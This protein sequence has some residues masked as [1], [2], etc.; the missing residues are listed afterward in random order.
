MYD[1]QC[2]GYAAAYLS[3]QC[4]LDTLYD[5]QCPGY[6]T[7]Y[8]NQQ[9]GI[10]ALYDSQCPG[11]AEAFFTQQ[12]TISGLY[13]TTCPNYDT[14]YFENQCTLDSLYNPGCSGYAEAKAIEDATPNIED[15]SADTVEEI[16]ENVTEI[17]SVES[18][19][20]VAITGDTIVDSVINEESTVAVA[21][22][23]EETTTD[24]FNVV[25]EEV[26]IPEE[27]AIDCLL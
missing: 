9:C 21:E 3:Q 12:C 25:V 11:Y 1:S 7:A 24:T 22:L 16:A 23:I 14:A 26:V 20:D 19:T 13:D 4:S 2:P 17:I 27:I 6:A 5:S 10:S 15:G 18:I 8:F